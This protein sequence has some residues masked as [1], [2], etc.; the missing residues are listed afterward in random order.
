MTKI[1]AYITKYMAKQSNADLMVI[2]RDKSYA[3]I[4]S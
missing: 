4:K 2:K 3:Y 1:L